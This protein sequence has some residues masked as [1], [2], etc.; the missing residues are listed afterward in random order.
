MTSATSSMLPGVSEVLGVHS[1][2]AGKTT[3]A[4]LRASGGA[5]DLK[6]GIAALFEGRPPQ[7]KGR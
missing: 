4:A 1:D 2:L 6:E 5:D 3:R 7:W